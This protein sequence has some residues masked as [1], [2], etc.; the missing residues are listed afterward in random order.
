MK[1]ASALTGASIA[2]PIVANVPT[3][4]ATEGPYY[5]RQSMRDLDQD[6]DLVKILDRVQEAGGEVV[7]LKGRVLD[8]EGVPVSGARVDIWQVGVN[9]AYLHTSDPRSNQRD[10]NFQGFGSYQ[11]ADDGSYWF[12]TIKPVAY[13]GRTPHIHVKVFTGARELTTQFYID[14]DPLNANDS[15]YNSMDEAEKAAVSM[16]FVMGPEYPEATVDIVL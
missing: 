14:G 4:S 10:E 1:L 6:N 9:G 12:R 3:P 8:Q 5:P 2:N 11:T 13:P 15:I 7:I 16:N